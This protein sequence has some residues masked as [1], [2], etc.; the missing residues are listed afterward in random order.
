MKQLTSVRIAL[1]I[2]H[3][4]YYGER[5]ATR[6]E[7]LPSIEQLGGF[8][9]GF[10]IQGAPEV[11]RVLVSAG[12]RG[13]HVWSIVNNIS[14]DRLRNV[15]RCEGLLIDKYPELT[16]DFHVLDRRDSPADDLVPGAQ[17]IFSR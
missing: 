7:T 14:D 11:E 5:M 3:V 15:Y 2:T 10:I 4:V 8:V 13:F 16:F 6:A 12:E 17:T 9:A 1:D